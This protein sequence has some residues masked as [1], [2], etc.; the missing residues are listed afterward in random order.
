MCTEIICVTSLFSRESHLFRGDHG[1]EYGKQKN[2]AIFVFSCIKSSL[3]VS[4]AM[5]IVS[6]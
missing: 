5:K 2:L 3:T 4:W 6:H 1:L